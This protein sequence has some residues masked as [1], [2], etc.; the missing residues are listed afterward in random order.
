MLSTACYFIFLNFRFSCLYLFKYTFKF[1]IAELFANVAHIMYTFC[2]PRRWRSGLAKNIEIYV[3][4][5][6]KLP[7]ISIQLNKIHT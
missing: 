3:K 2:G 4:L 5:K 7:V 6:T 1:N